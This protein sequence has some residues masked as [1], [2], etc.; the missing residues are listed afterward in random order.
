MLW[1]EKNFSHGFTPTPLDRFGRPRKDFHKSALGA[2]K[3][4]P[5]NKKK[6]KI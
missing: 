3:T 4:V 5:G 6:S 2:E 1:G